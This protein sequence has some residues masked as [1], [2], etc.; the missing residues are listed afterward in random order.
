MMEMINVDGKEIEVIR[1]DQFE[2]AYA[3]KLPTDVVL[4]APNGT[5]VLVN[6]EQASDLTKLGY[7]KASN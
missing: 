2:D 6:S 7:K 3:Q 1:L 4:K 5:F